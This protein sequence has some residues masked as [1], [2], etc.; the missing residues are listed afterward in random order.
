MSFCKR[1]AARLLPVGHS[2]IADDKMRSRSVGAD[3]GQDSAR[4]T[5]L[6]A[7]LE[8][9]PK[10]HLVVLDSLLSHLVDL[11]RDTQASEGENDSDYIAKLGAALGPCVVRPHTDSVKT[12]NDRFPSL[13]LM[14]GLKHYNE[15]F[16]PVLE[17][18][19]KVEEG[20]YAPKRQRTKL[21]DQRI[22]RQ[23]MQR[24]DTKGKE[25]MLKE[26]IERRTGSKGMSSFS[27]DRVTSEPEE[28]VP[29]D[30]H[31]SQAQGVGQDGKDGDKTPTEQVALP[32][33][34]AAE[35]RGHSVEPSEDDGANTQGFSTPPEAS[36]EDHGA[37]DSE[38]Y[39]V[40][41][42]TRS[43]SLRMPKRALQPE[44]LEEDDAADRVAPSS[45][46]PTGQDSDQAIGLEGTSAG[47]TEQE[48]SVADEEDLDKPLAASTSLSRSQTGS[49]LKRNPG[50]SSSLSRSRGPRPMSMHG[51]PTHKAAVTTSSSP[52][53]A[54]AAAAA[55][56]T[57]PTGSPL[58]AGAAGVRARAAMYE[59]RRGQG[60]A[61]TDGSKSP[62][63][64]GSEG[65]ATS[66][67]K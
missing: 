55:T 60:G 37:E 2:G 63:A 25:R 9:L 33:P 67:P 56:A 50:L 42:P 34:P 44:E 58:P 39:A 7:F 18:K 49:N 28:M 53:P 61:G 31:Y 13:F 51:T 4:I 62:A 38:A 41:E 35:A 8:R 29:S 52:G 66:P 6:V 40:E 24:Q 19:N 36:S 3:V 26:E 48:G 16:P 11:V 30:T 47:G 45:G 57:S 22:S 5:A 1:P 43:N 23:A 10:I 27:R 64:A 32:L 17:K 46:R 54:V 21:I 65:G 12:L 59:Q 14:D 15:I 20:R